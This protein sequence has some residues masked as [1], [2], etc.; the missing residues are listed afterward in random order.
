MMQYDYY[1][2]VEPDIEFFCDITYD[3]FAFSE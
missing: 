3:P 2:R 1:W